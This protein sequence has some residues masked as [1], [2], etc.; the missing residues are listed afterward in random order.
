MLYDTVGPR[1]NNHVEA[2][3]RSLNG[4]LVAAHPNVYRIV[5]AFK[6]F[7][8]RMQHRVEELNLGANPKRPRPS[9]IRK[10]DNMKNLKWLFEAGTLTLATFLERLSYLI[11]F[12]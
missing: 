12:R 8:L 7:D 4:L 6:Q 1:T 9:V 3:H 11:N 5:D 2:Y 10:Y